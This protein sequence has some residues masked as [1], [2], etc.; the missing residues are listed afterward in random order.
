[1]DD[2]DAIVAGLLRPD[3]ARHGEKGEYQ[4]AREGQ[5]S[6]HHPSP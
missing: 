2:A 1:M 5:S 3:D 6:H 4:N